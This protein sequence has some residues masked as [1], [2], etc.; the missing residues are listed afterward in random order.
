MAG[1]DLDPIL[2]NLG[3]S[4]I[5]VTGVSVNVAI[6]N[7]VVDAVNLG[8]SVVVPRDAV[9][10]IPREYA[11]AVIDNTLSLLAAI[12]TTAELLAAW[13]ACSVGGLETGVRRDLEWRADERRVGEEWFMTFRSRWLQDD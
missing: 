13:P 4:T 1:T 9:C 10:G 12:T 6:T 2:R 7:L 5:V 8:Y 3:V 11:D